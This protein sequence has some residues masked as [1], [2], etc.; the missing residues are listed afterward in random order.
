[1][2]IPNSVLA[3]LY[4]RQ[5]SCLL[6]GTSILAK[7]ISDVAAKHPDW[8]RNQQVQGGVAAYNSGVGNI[9]TQAG[10][11]VGTTHNDYSNDVI[12]RAQALHN[13]GFFN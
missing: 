3:F 4:T 5:R 6:A 2:P 7:G 8:P 10:I 11:D 9:Q 1:M 13:D 12:A